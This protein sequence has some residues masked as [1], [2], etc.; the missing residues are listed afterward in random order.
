ML[1]RLKKIWKRIVEYWNKFNRK[2]K[3]IFISA[4][5]IIVIALI[6]LYVAF[7]KTNSIIIRYCESASEATEVR[8]LLQGSGISSSIDESAGS[9]VVYIDENDEVDAKLV[10]GSNNISADGYSLSDALDSSFSDTESDKQ[11]RYVAYLEDKFEDDLERIDGVKRADVNI[12]YSDA[13]STVFSE[14]QNASITAI[15]ELTKDM[16]DDV[17]SN[18]GQLLATNVG[19][20]NTNN[21]VVMDAKGNLLYSG[22]SNQGG[23]SAA[24]SYNQKFKQSIE[25]SITDNIKDAMLLTQVYTD[26]KVIPNMN[27][28][29]DV[30]NSTDTNYTVPQGSDEGLKSYSYEVNSTGGISASGTPGTESNDQDTTYE[31]TTGNG[32]SQEYSLRQYQWLQDSKITTTDKA[33]GTIN[34][35]DSSVSV[36]AV[37][38]N[39]IKEEDAES[40]GLLDNMSW[41]EYQAANSKPTEIQVADDDNFYSMI[42]TG[43]GIPQKNIKIMAYSINVFYDAEGTSSSTSYVIQIILAVLIVL[44]LGFIVYRSTKPVTVAETEPELSVED[45]LASTKEKQA[46]LEDIDLQDKSEARRAIEKFVDENPEAVALLLR[47]WLNDGWD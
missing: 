38:Y 2:Q 14:K 45:M 22:E 20:D 17:A 1:D 10:L 4:A 9:Y 12:K 44:L 29:F 47:N 32:Q 18:I 11:N 21:V 41:E 30:V 42:S 25:K 3:T 24:S 36:T 15:L 23:N 43:T 26:I 28:N 8:D 35:D 40:Q 5:S 7:S 6:I 39:M 37:K 16:D 34:Y 31:I 27:I 33:T 46:P 13:S 19:S